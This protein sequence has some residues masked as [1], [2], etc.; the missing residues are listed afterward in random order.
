MDTQTRH[1]LEPDAIES[2]RTSV[3]GRRW[4][5]DES[6]IQGHMMLLYF[7]TG[8]AQV[9]EFESGPTSPRKALRRTAPRSSFVLAFEKRGKWKTRRSLIIVDQIEAVFATLKTET[10]R[11]FPGK[12]HFVS[13]LCLA[14]VCPAL[15]GTAAV[16][17]DHDPGHGSSAET[18]ASGAWR[19]DQQPASPDQVQTEACH[20]EDVGKNVE[21]QRQRGLGCGCPFGT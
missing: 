10:Y 4:C 19:P 18:I 9:G 14:A 6:G 17:L 20:T 21:L 11:S 1:S 15:R 12:C 3:I 5:W 8:L 16:M 7:T 2:L 13:C